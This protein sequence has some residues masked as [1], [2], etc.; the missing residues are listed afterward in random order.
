MPSREEKRQKFGRVRQY[1]VYESFVIFIAHLNFGTVV[2]KILSLMKSSATQPSHIV[3][4][5]EVLGDSVSQ[6]A[7][8]ND[9]Q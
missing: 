4:E 7:G 6:L 5:T 8:N 1:H 9:S 3:D 2:Q